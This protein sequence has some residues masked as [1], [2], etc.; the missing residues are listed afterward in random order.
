M[1]CKDRV[2]EVPEP[3]SVHRIRM[4]DGTVIHLRQHGNPNGPR[5]VLS[6]GNG[7]AIDLYYPFWSLLAQDFEL[8]VFDLRNH[9]WNAVGAQA[10]HIVPALVDDHDRILDEIDVRYGKKPKIGIFHSVSALASLVSS[11]GNCDFAARILFDP[12]LCK[13]NDYPEE[14]DIATRRSTEAALRRTDTFKSLDEF[15]DLLSWLPVYHRTVPGVLD[16]AART[17]LK[18]NDGGDGYSLRC[19]RT[20]EAQIINYARMYTVWVDL[21]EIDCPTKVVGADPVLPYSYLPTFDLSQ[22]HSLDYDFLPDTTHLL[23]L[24]QP[25]ECVAVIR[26]FL[27]QHNLL[28]NR[29]V[30][31]GQ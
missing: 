29:K 31:I 24:E 18:K 7:L 6:H 22:I 5:L 16:L 26:E 1:A 11:T 4:D 25:K 30:H 13:P 19:P 12:P 17:M 3:L 14:Y 9:G 8:F 21:E 23:Q 15:V 20:Y 2:W 28:D 27:E 10:D